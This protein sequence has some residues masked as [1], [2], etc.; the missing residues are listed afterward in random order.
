MRARS[1]LSIAAPL[2]SRR[3]FD[4]IYIMSYLDGRQSN[5]VRG[6]ARIAGH[7]ARFLAAPDVRRLDP[8]LLCL[9]RDC[10][11][12]YLTGMSLPIWRAGMLSQIELR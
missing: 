8:E 6:A 2:S 4:V 7:P 3:N 9:R 1:F 12:R 11:D 5:G 10:L